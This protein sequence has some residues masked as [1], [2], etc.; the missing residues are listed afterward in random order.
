MEV[1]DGDMLMYS[2][3]IG[4]IDF[5]FF[6]LSDDASYNAASGTQEVQ[7]NNMVFL[8]F[9]GAS[10]LL[11][12]V[13][14]R[15]AAALAADRE[16][17]LRAYSGMAAA[18]CSPQNPLYLEAEGLYRE[19]QPDV[20]AALELLEQNGYDSR[21]EDGMLTARGGRLTLRLLV[22]SEDDRRSAAAGLIA[23]QFAQLGIEVLV[24]E[25]PFTEY[26]SMLALGDYDMYIGEIKLKADM[27]I[28]ALLPGGRA[29][30]YT[31]AGE[32]FMDSYR[33]WRAGGSL[34]AFNKAFDEELPFL[35][36]LFRRGSVSFSRKL[37]YDVTATE[38]DIFYNILDWE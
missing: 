28:A 9:N 30:Y 26:T 4:L 7:L 17:L 19:R 27:D 5:A 11:S 14:I 29:A 32:E 1:E 16:A 3:K 10:P 37:A 38:Q 2:L 12:D 22:N 24:E 36:L 25:H 35:P 13:I 21:D 31:A 18:A 15:Q 34:S 20:A 23:E 6:D 8:G 33:S